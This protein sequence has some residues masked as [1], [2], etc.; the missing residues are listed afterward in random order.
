MAGAGR[1][2]EQHGDPGQGE[3]DPRL[4][5][6]RL[7]V[8]RLVFR[9]V[10][11]PDVRPVGDE[12][13]PPVPPPF[14]GEAGVEL[15]GRMLGQAAQHGRRNAGAGV[16]VAGGVGR[17]H[18]QAACG[19]MGDDP[20]YGV[21]AAVVLAEDLGEKAPDGS[22]GAEHSVAVLEIMLIESVEDAGFAQGVGERQSLV[23]RKASADLLQ[24]G[25]KRSHISR[26]EVART[27][28]ASRRTPVRTRVAQAGIAS[29]LHYRW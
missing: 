5:D 11:H 25:H 17:T 6:H 22:D 14:V 24:G 20:G 16:A 29:H 13:V 15:L 23:A 4:L 26:V 3:A 10:R 2:R 1:Q 18:L 8:D 7:R 27:W 9:R 21:A 12:H 28:E 19:P